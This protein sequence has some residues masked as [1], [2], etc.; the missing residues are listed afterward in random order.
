M[1]QDKSSLSGHGKGLR[2][3]QAI[4]MREAYQVEAKM[5]RVYSDEGASR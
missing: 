4:R 1:Y 3:G 2:V 5:R